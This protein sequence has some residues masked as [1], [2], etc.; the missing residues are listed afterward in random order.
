MVSESFI[1][2]VPRSSLFWSLLFRLSFSCSRPLMTFWH[3]LAFLFMYFKSPAVAVPDRLLQKTS[4]S[5][6]GVV[7]GLA[8]HLLSTSSLSGLLLAIRL[9]L[10]PTGFL[11]SESELLSVSSFLFRV[12]AIGI[13]SPISS[14][15]Q[16]MA[17]R[18]PIGS[19]LT[20]RTPPSRA[21][22]GRPCRRIRAPLCHH[23]RPIRGAAMPLP[24]TNQGAATP[25]PPTNQGA[26]IPLPLANGMRR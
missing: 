18:Q 23:R 9:L 19:K 16:L 3:S 22:V 6:A 11:Q 21:G 2:W 24:L 14:F 25:L 15:L 10:L 12:L 5:S 7:P 20:P 13:A 8:L 1:I 17:V 26:S 4:S